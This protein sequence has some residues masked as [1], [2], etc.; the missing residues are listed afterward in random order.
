MFLYIYIYI[1]LFTSMHLLAQRI[2]LTGLRKLLIQT[3][4]TMYKCAHELGLS[5]SSRATQGSNSILFTPCKCNVYIQIYMYVLYL[6]DSN[7]NLLSPLQHLSYDAS[8]RAEDQKPWCSTR[9]SRASRRKRQ[10]AGALASDGSPALNLNN[11]DP[12][13]ANRFSNL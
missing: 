9:Q 7:F 6:H 5:H 11:K 12:N 4:H 10:S 2:L 1:R 3:R 8:Q 13:A